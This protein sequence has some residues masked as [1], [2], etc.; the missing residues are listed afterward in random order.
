LRVR[1]TIHTHRATITQHLNMAHR[2]AVPRGRP[3]GK[4]Y[5]ACCHGA[6][7][8]CRVPRPGRPHGLDGLP[9]ESCT[10]PDAGREPF[11]RGAS[12]KV[13]LGESGASAFYGRP[14]EASTLDEPRIPRLQ[15]CGVSNSCTMQRPARSGT[16]GPGVWGW[17]ARCRGLVDV[18]NGSAQATHLHALAMHVFGARL[19]ARSDLHG[20]RP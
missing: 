20:S 15:P 7:P 16:R 3:W 8:D 4:T 10:R 1:L 19:V 17:N 13:T 9:L 2:L 18:S 12:R 11:Y 14:W 6:R 5:A